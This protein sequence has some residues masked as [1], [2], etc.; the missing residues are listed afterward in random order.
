MDKELID[1]INTSVEDSTE[2][3]IAADL[4]QAITDLGFSLEQ[5]ANLLEA[6][7]KDD[8]DAYDFDE[9]DLETFIYKI[10]TS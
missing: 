5:A 9:D 3:A 8:P 6:E 1:L 4:I 10:E 2:Q 7:I